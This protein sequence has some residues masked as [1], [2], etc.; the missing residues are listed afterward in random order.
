MVG[1][2][3]TRTYVLLSMIT[4]TCRLFLAPGPH[5]RSEIVSS[6]RS[7]V[8]MFLLVCGSPAG[9]PEPAGESQGEGGRNNFRISP[10]I[11]K[12]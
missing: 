10:E 8:R 7:C 6:G 9:P 5:I 2:Y 3:H 11:E 12:I 4:L 1:D